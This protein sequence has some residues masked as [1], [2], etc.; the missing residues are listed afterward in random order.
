MFHP[1]KTWQELGYATESDYLKDAAMTDDI[2]LELA[3]E[4][5]LKAAPSHS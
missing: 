3:Q 2:L 5:R 1:K 4:D